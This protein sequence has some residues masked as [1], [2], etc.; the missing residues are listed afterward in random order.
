MTNWTYKAK[1]KRG[2][3]VT[4]KLTAPDRGDA[5]AELQKKDLVVLQLE[6]GTGKRGGEK[7]T[8]KRA[9]PRAT[10]VELVI[11]TRQ[12]AT[13]VGAGIS[14]LE[15]IDVLKDQAE[16]PG[17]RSTCETIADQLRGGAD[18]SAAMATC[19]KVFNELYV[20]MVSA[21]EVSGQMDGVLERLA[22]YQEASDELIREVK[23]AMT[24][25]V[26][27]LTLVLGITA[28]L[29]IFIVPTFGEIF[30]E[31]DAKLPALTAF[32]LGTS[33]W[34]RA[35]IGTGVLGIVAFIAALVAFKRTDRGNR[36]FDIVKLR[37]PVFG[38]LIKKVSLARF[39]RTFGTLIKS[40]V[41]ILATLDIVAKTAGN[42][43]IADAVRAS[44]SSVQAGDLLSEPLAENKVFPPMVV[45]MI[46]IGERS[47]A[48]EE[49]LEKIA[50]FYDREVKAQIKALTS[51]IEPILISF[52]GVIVG[53]VVMSVFLP[54]LDL[55]GQLSGQK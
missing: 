19:P 18:L 31:M 33:D 55:V 29:M 7:R 39:S 21:G 45:R 2:K 4:G 32:V 12:L 22:D 24:Y 20:S 23:S 50:E 48:L 36:I 38:P 8:K 11:F 34:M 13:M 5:V 52:M 3:T 54:I 17:M 40:G 16:T 46:A 41:P 10:R 49:L 47:G 35:N 51:L 27:S 9:K 42:V 1:D 44:S 15:A 30:E 43:V 14:L 6:K 26:I 53:G 37:L 28:F 25:P